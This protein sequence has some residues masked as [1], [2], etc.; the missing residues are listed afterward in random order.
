VRHNWQS[1]LRSAWTQLHQTWRE[2]S[3]IIAALHL[4]FRVRILATF[5]NAGGSEI[6]DVENDAKFRI[7]DPLRK[8]WAGWARSLN[9]FLK[10]YLRPNLRNLVA[11]KSK[12]L[13]CCGELDFDKIPYTYF[14][15]SS[16]IIPLL[17]TFL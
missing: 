15:E 5:S 2:D 1:S 9:Q 3:A 6:S 8:L 13:V 10:L 17:T 14:Q 7:F 16:G 4:C 11:I 12:K